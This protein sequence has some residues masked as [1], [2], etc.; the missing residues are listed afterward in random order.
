MIACHLY[1]I[2]SLLF[3]YIFNSDYFERLCSIDIFNQLFYQYGTVDRL[4]V[5]AVM[6]CLLLLGDGSPSESAHID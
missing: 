3:D 1:S 6:C 2:S 4:P 5:T